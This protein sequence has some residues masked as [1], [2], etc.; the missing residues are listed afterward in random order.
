MLLA[1]LLGAAALATA[2]P[3]PIEMVRQRPPQDEVIYFLLPDRFENGDPAND[4]GGLKGDRLQTGYDPT[5]K[6]FY[7]GGDLKGVSKRL[8]YIQGLGATAVWLAPVFKNKPVQGGPGQESA[9]FHGYWITDFTRVDPHF[10]SND[11][12][13]ALV[14][15]A[16]ARGMKVYLDIVTNHTAD[17]IQLQECA[18]RPC[19]YRSKGDY[20]FSRRGGLSGPAIN[21]GFAGDHVAG[22]ANWAKLTRP[23]FA[24][25]PF[26]PPAERSAKVPAWL[27]DPIHYHNRGNS[28]FRG[29]SST[30]G[31]FVGLDD[32]A[33]EHPRVVAGLIDIYGRWIDEFG[34][35]G[36]RIDTEQHVNPEFWQAFVPAMQARARAAG[37]PNFHIFGEIS[38][39]DLDVG[40]LA[41]HTH[42]DGLPNVLDF[43]TWAA[44]VQAIGGR[45]PTSTLTRLF[46]DDVLY[47]GGTVT[48]ATNATFVSNHD[49]GRFAMLVRQADPHALPDEIAARVLLGHALMM[50]S[51]GVPTLY[52][53][54]E[55]GFVGIGDDNE[56]RQPMFGSQVAGYNGDIRLGT[57]QRTTTPAFDPAHPFYR[58]FAEM[59]RVRAADVRLR[60]GETIVRHAGDTPGIF[61]FARRLPG[62]K[63]E[64]LVVLN[65]AATAQSANIAVD[66]ASLRWRSSLGPC[67]AT[68]AAPGSYR[69]TLA[70]LAY[71]VCS[72]EES[73]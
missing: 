59:A 23:D 27:N 9:G 68:A 1:S 14:A 28:T 55:Q 72:T 62:Q 71:A 25:T 44:A 37:I 2:T 36:Y 57:R 60:R 50:F 22:P 64:T 51:R 24:Y 58:A 26:V 15:A 45:A 30:Y 49:K 35:D 19:E 46:A 16:H 32:L 54:D 70:P 4:R 6:N 52:Y 53:G 43:A 17:V 63:G 12:L 67:A 61:A 20:P 34:I 10:G 65:T 69:I 66:P 13:K 47:K 33:T 42:N 40:R 29:E 31:D 18:G 48:A 8:D 41:R 5:A 21:D 39:D 11:D 7:E 73:Q 3:V 56:A 38:T